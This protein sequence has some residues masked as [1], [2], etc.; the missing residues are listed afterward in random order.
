MD[1]Q[2]QTVINIIAGA[3][4]SVIG[5]FAR[6][7]WDADRELRADLSKLREE[8]P[9]TYVAK[10]DLDRRLDKIDNVLNQIWHELR[11]KA[12]KGGQ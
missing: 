5:W 4:L 1:G 3:A 12:D 7:L 10:D 6:I 8:L 11:E 2:W 9:K